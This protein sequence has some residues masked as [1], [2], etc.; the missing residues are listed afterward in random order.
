MTV[1][2][3]RPRMPHAQQQLSQFYHRLL[4]RIQD[5]AGLIAAGERT[6]CRWGVPVRMA[7]SSSTAAAGAETMDRVE[8]AVRCAFGGRARAGCGVS[9]GEAAVTLPRWVFSGERRAFQE[10]DGPMRRS[11]VVTSRCAALFPE[12]D[13]VGKQIQFATWTVISPVE[14]RRRVATC[15]TPASMWTCDDRL[16]PLSAASA[17]RAEFSCRGARA[18]CRRSDRHDAAGSAG[19]KSEMR[20]NSCRSR[21]SSPRRWI[22]VASHGQASACSPAAR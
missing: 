20:Q 3:S 21:S 15:G 11:A 12:R 18:R 6:V 4:E 7:R 9:R 13:A 19:V 10:S 22:N 17:L 14:H 2:M 8:R 5:A 1:S 16:R